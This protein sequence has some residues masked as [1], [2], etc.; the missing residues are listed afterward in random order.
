MRCLLFAESRVQSCWSEDM[1]MKTYQLDIWIN[2]FFILLPKSQFLRLSWKEE[3]AKNLVEIVWVA[4]LKHLK[5]WDGKHFTANFSCTAMKKPLILV[6][7]TCMA[8]GMSSR[9][10]GGCTHTMTVLLSLDTLFTQ[11]SEDEESDE[12]QPPAV[13]VER[14]SRILT[15]ME[16]RI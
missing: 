4:L 15:L 8:G 10:M 1:Q 2:R 6:A 16:N 13:E 7:W 12:R 14:L 3:K 9:M 5:V 11:S